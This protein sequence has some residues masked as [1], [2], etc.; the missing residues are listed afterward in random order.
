[1]ATL[2]DEIVAPMRMDENV[3]LC[4]SSGPVK[5]V[6]AVR[7]QMHQL[8]LNVILNARQAI[9]GSGDLSVVM[10]QVESSLVISVQ[11]TGC[12]IPP[13]KLESLFRPSQSSRPGG[14][15]IGLYQCKQIVNAH[16]GTI[17]I[18]SDEGKGTQVTIELPVAPIVELRG[19]DTM[20]HT[21]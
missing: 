20:A 8:L 14:L 12:G 16:G 11:D 19:T 10:N 2:V 9:S 18:Q 15:G 5:P 1:M 3:K 4:F 21:S 6:M 7:E 13:A 17:Q